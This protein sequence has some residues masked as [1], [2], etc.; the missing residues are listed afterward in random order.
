LFAARLCVASFGNVKPQ[1]P[2][3][4]FFT[5]ALVGQFSSGTYPECD[6][7][8]RYAPFRGPGHFKMQT[9]LKKTGGAECYFK[10]GEKSISFRVVEC[11]SYGILRIREL[12]LQR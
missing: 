4:F 7:D 8:I 11:P 6:G 2:P 9:A 5:D 12:V 3:V 10:R 1:P